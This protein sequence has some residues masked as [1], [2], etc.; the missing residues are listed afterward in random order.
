M[1]YGISRA[2]WLTKRG[3]K[4]YSRVTF[5]GFDQTTICK[6]EGA[7]KRQAKHYNSRLIFLVMF[8]TLHAC[9]VLR[10]RVRNVN[11]SR[12]SIEIRKSIET[13]GSRYYITMSQFTLGY[14]Q[15][16]ILK[17]LQNKQT[18]K[19]RQFYIGLHLSGLST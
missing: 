3:E 1:A 5:K 18:H 4:V 12:V 2:D 15:N 16:V 14:N 6:V 9:H 17:A 19:K 8:I 11:I 13:D 10:N 7:P